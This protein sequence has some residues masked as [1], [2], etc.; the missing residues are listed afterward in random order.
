MVVASIQFAKIRFNRI[1]PPK[2]DPQCKFRAPPHL[3]LPCR[4]RLVTGGMLVP[5][6]IGRA[7]GTGAWDACQISGSL[8][9]SF[10]KTP[11]PRFTVLV[12]RFSFLLLH[13]PC[14]WSHRRHSAVTNF[15]SSFEVL[16]NS[17]N[18]WLTCGLYSYGKYLLAICRYCYSTPPIWRRNSAYALRH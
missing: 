9:R 10:F 11:V 18:I 4:K 16:F 2:E 5:G 17:R 6:T 8:Y 15:M 14:K 7:G 12:S 13:L 3:G 1:H